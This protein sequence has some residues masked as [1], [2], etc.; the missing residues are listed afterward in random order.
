MQQSNN[1]KFS[2]QL[3]KALW[4][5][6]SFKRKRQ[7]IL[8]LGL[9]SLCAIFEV[10]SLGA[11]VPFL[12]VLISPEKLLNYPVT[13]KIL[14]FFSYVEP[15]YFAVPI[16]TAFVVLIITS[17]V[18][19][20]TFLWLSSYIAL[21]TG[22]DI[23]AEVYEK[24]LYQPFSKH[25]ATNSSD[26]VSGIV[27]KVHGIVY[28]IL[29]PALTLISS[30]IF[31]IAILIV[32]FAVS[33][34][35]TLISLLSF[36]L[37][38][39]LMGA[40]IK[41]RLI[42]N[43]IKIAHE[44]DAVIRVLHE[45]LGGIRDVLLEGLQQFFCDVYKK[46]ETPL[47]RAQAEV[48]FLAQSPR[49]FMEA[50]GMI[51]IAS[52]ALY[53]SFKYGDI[54]P[55]FPT[56]GLFA[57]G[58]Q[59]LLPAMQQAYGSWASI[60]GSY[61]SLLDVINLLGHPTQNFVNEKSLV[62][63]KE[64]AFQNVKYRYTEDSEYILK[65]ISFRV[66]KGMRVGLV[67]ST[68]S[69]KSTLLDILMGLLEPTS[70]HVLIDGDILRNNDIRAWQKNIAHVPQTV[71]LSDNSIAANIAF[72]IERDSIDWSLMDKAI[73]NSMLQDFVGN[74]PD[75]YFRNVGERGESLSG[76][77]RQRVGI[78]RA[79]YKN[80]T[81]L[82]LDEAT[83]ALDNLTEQSVMSAIYKNNPEVTIFIVAHRL[84]TIKSCDLIIEL[85]E[86]MIKSQGSYQELLLNSSSFK[87][88]AMLGDHSEKVK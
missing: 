30:I 14:A 37:I 84:S 57:F 49:Y 51:L 72:G 56:L 29:L 2:L 45:G 25:L 38:Y 60:T 76:G 26:I 63:K 47:R 12:A 64:L 10:V 17:S 19:R 42:K 5:H 50:F 65:D 20:L 18:F 8:L 78:A 33:P 15:R 13:I 6:L 4:L 31:M 48:T 55:F 39:L 7:F 11:V 70:G 9:M 53:L 16:T 87:K 36:G 40:L 66:E 61:A 81:V 24:T 86:G 73:V 43:S 67:G 52:F 32:L 3:I 23:S 83:S 62:F 34:K 44:Q 74:D 80:S 22:A 79:L 77:Q 82:V 54:T 59:R 85:E 21:S 71:Y 75:S 46:A 68:G 88:M 58:A 1:Q 27:T 69:G 41:K 28:G 35:V